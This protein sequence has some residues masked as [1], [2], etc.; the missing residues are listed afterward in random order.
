[1]FQGLSLYPRVPADV[2]LDIQD[3]HPRP[4]EARLPSSRKDSASE[5]IE[6]GHG[7]KFLSVVAIAEED[8]KR[9]LKN[10]TVTEDKNYHKNEG[11]S[12]EKGLKIYSNQLLFKCI[13]S[14]NKHSRTK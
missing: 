7:A 1:M 2:Y 4:T 3:I 10:K 11:I 13:I 6:Q 8:V 9:Q 14:I 5:N 12:F